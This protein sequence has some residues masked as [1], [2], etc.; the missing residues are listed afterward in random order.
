M[1][2]MKVENPSTYRIVS[3]NDEYLQS[4][5]NIYGEISREQL[6]NHTS[7]ELKELFDWPDS[8]YDNTI[9][10]YLKVIETGKP[11]K[12]VDELPTPG[13]TLFFETVY[14]PVFD[15]EKICTH[16]LY[17]SRDI[18][19]RK[20]AEQ[21]LKESEQKYR[22]LT[23]TSTDVIIT[24]NLD[25]KLT[26]INPIVEKLTGFNTKHFIGH[27]FMEIVSPESIDSAVEHFKKGIRGDK[28]PFLEI[29]IMHK[30]GS[31][32]GC[33]SKCFKSLWD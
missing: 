5:R 23:D 8:L 28:L 3:F 14:Y 25:G 4:A 10:N 33:R 31:K 27:S 11:V 24:M 9:R 6:L 17:T 12:I 2:L 18:T 29:Y 26:Y 7:E 1:I 20:K 32:I 30:D 15:S 21:A 22:S 19:E 13:T 16:I